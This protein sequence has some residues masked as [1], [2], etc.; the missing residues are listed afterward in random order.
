[1]EEGKKINIVESLIELSRIVNV[2]LTQIAIE[3]RDIGH[4]LDV[5][6]ERSHSH[7]EA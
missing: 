2:G 5:L 3:L 7:D 6:E 1:M 4:R